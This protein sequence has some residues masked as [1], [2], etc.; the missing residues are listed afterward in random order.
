M[1]ELRN[2]TLRNLDIFAGVGHGVSP[3]LRLYRG[4]VKRMVP[5]AFI[6]TETEFDIYA[7]LRHKQ[8]IWRRCGGQESVKNS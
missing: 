2:V 3:A 5:C 6:Y 7:V 8:G 1:E 4:A